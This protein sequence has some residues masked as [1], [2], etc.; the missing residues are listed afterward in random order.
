M[1][2]QHTQQHLPEWTSGH[3]CCDPRPLYGWTHCQSPDLPR[4]GAD[5]RTGRFYRTCCGFFLR[6]QNTMI[7]THVLNKGGHGVKSPVDIFITGLGWSVDTGIIKMCCFM[8]YFLVKRVR[9]FFGI[10]YKLCYEG[11]GFCFSWIRPQITFGGKSDKAQFSAFLATRLQDVF[12]P[13]QETFKTKFIWW[14]LSLRRRLRS[15]NSERPQELSPRSRFCFY[16]RYTLM[17]VD[18]FPIE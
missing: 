7:Y 10:I 2:G 12:L 4:R 18:Y 13:Q 1:R 6:V 16:S 15:E 8:Y 9:R 3:Y 17:I 14:R 5:C 11:R